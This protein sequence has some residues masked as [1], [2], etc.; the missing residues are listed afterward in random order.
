MNNRNI[1]SQLISTLEKKEDEHLFPKINCSWM[2]QNGKF[3]IGFQKWSHTDYIRY[4]AIHI[5][6]MEKP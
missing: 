1:N 6:C 4:N 2:K 5:Q 3:V